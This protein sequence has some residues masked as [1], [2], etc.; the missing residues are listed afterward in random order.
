[1]LLKGL[2]GKRDNARDAGN[3]ANDGHPVKMRDQRGIGTMRSPP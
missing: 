2:A 1:M 3:F